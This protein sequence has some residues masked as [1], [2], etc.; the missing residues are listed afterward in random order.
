MRMRGF[1]LVEL[2]LVIVLL[3]IMATATTAYLGLGAR[4]YSEVNAREQLLAQSR[5]AIERLTRELR[6]AT[7][8]SIR[9]KRDESANAY[10]CIEYVPFVFSGVYTDAGFDGVEKNYVD[11][12]S[13]R[14]LGAENLSGAQRLV[15]YPRHNDDIYLVGKDT[16]ASLLKVAPFVD[17]TNP[18][19]SNHSAR[20][21][22]SS[23]AA[24]PN[25]DDHVFPR[26][27]PEQRFYLTTAPVSYCLVN[28]ELLRYAGYG[29]ANSQPVPSDFAAGG[30]TGILMA[31]GIANLAGEAVFRYSGPSLTRNSVVNLLLHFELQG[32]DDTFF[33]H[34]VHLANVP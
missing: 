7:P 19:A 23:P 2:I 21:A 33:N 20:L 14:D 5:F 3:G 16:Q 24:Y 11:V 15:I 13:S 18:D 1:T 10:Q 17:T 29:Y 30:V 34:E 25:I 12:V 6:G 4:M 27:S 26:R 22:L 32:Q 28:K 8:N 31:E 9:L